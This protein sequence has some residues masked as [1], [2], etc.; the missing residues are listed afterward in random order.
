MDAPIK[1]E[2]RERRARARRARAALR[3]APARLAVPVSVAAGAAP[4]APG[5]RRAER[6]ISGRARGEREAAGQRSV[7]G[8]CGGEERGV[9]LVAAVVDDREG[10]PVGRQ[11]GIGAKEGIKDS[12]CGDGNC[13]GGQDECNAGEHREMG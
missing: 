6:H 13:E 1:R 9:D 10:R 12:L 11:R 3:A 4:D 7:G 5:P 8:G 2:L